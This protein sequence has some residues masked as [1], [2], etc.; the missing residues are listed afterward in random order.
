MDNPY[1]TPSSDTMESSAPLHQSFRLTPSST[2]PD[3]SPPFGTFRDAIYFTLIQQVP[4][5]MLSALLLDGGLVFK[6]VGIASIAFWFLALIIL[7]RR[8]RTVPESDILVLKWGFLPL[9]FV[10]FILW[11]VAATILN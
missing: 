2:S 8:G 5:L 6:R 4:L 7:I 1:Q 10:T 11:S 3:A 9:L